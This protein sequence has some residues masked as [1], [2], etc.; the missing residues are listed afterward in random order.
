MLGKGM[1]IGF[2]LVAIVATLVVARN[3]AAEGEVVAVGSAIVD[4][5]GEGA[6]SVVV[7]GVDAPG[8]G[9]WSIDVTYDD[10]V[11]AAVGCDP[12]NGS[13]CNPAFSPDTV[14]ISGANANGIEGDVT[15]GTISFRCVAEGASQLSVSI[16]ILADST[17]G[18]P[19][20]IE[21]ATQNGGI[22]CQDVV[23]PTA[24][25]T[26]APIATSTPAAGNVPIAGSGPGFGKTDPTT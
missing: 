23:D 12:Q 25:G 9:A 1:R 2:L 7:Q 3:A 4:L 11:V 26:Q 17:I 16:N 10:E 15:I 22:T 20:T 6:V 18:D 13:V 14:R 5:G 21:A 19:Q 8:L 24:T